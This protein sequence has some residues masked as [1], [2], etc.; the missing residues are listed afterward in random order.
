MLFRGHTVANI[1]R[2]TSKCAL[3][4]LTISLHEIIL[5]KMDIV[6]YL[7]ISPPLQ[8]L[9]ISHFPFLFLSI[10]NSEIQRSPSSLGIG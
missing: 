9:K 6:M 4:K 1:N 8:Q 5:K 3:L 7:N 2:V 10:Q